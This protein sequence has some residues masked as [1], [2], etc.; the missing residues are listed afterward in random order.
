MRF[1][2]RHH[3]FWVM[4]SFCVFSF[5]TVGGSMGLLPT[6]GNHCEG[7]MR[8]FDEYLFWI[9]LTIGLVGLCV[10]IACVSTALLP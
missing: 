3:S 4:C 10:M 5:G 7:S 9:S 1:L 6:N 2:L 8:R